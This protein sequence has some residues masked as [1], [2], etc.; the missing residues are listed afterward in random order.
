[1]NRLPRRVDFMDILSHVSETSL[2]TLKARVMEARRKNPWI[3]DE[4]GIKLLGKLETHLPEETRK[5]ILDTNMP[6][7]LSTHIALRAMKF[8]Q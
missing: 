5:R 3:R 6:G 2:I 8:D 7:S 1:M 4:M